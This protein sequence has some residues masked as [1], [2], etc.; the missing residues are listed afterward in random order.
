MKNIIKILTIG[1]VALTG[2]AGLPAVVAQERSPDGQ[3]LDQLAR[4]GSDLTKLHHVDFL[5]RFPTRIAAERAEL[6]LIGLAFDTKIESGKT[7]DERVI[8]ASKV[9]YP[10]ESDL[11][12]LR[13]KLEGIAAEGHGVY[14]GWR[15]RVFEPKAQAAQ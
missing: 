11:M 3:N 8:R 1:L 13:D 12:G 7:P 15:A 5:L 14:E 10:V 4:S 2:L 9:M 6:Q